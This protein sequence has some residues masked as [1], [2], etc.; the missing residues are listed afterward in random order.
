[1]YQLTKDAANVIPFVMV[2]S[3]GAEV[4]G[5]AGTFTVLLSKAGGAFGASAGAKAELGSGWYTYTATAGEC[6]TLGALALRVTGAGAGQQNLVYQV[7]ASVAGG[8]ATEKT[9]TLTDSATGLPIAQAV[10]WVTTDAAG[11]N[12]IASGTTDD[13][14]QVTFYLDAGTYYVWRRK[15][16]WNFVNP[17]LEVVA[18]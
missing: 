10:V 8:G 6:D 1:M 5:L 13:F 17:D 16:G 3:S 4:T 7:A 18:P 14:G 9:Y 12:R 15:A 11:L 2:D